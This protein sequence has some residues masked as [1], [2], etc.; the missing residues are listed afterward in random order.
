[1]PTGAAPLVTDAAQHAPQMAAEFIAAWRLAGAEQDHGGARVCGIVDVDW[2]KA[3]RI[4]M[5]PAVTH[6]R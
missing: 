4:V 2:Q 6:P 3:P 1:M 5:G